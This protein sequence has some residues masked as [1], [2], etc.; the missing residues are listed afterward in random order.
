MQQTIKLTSK[1]KRL[2]KVKLKYDV[3]RISAQDKIDAKKKVAI[4]AFS[5]ASFA[6]WTANCEEMKEQNRSKDD[7]VQIVRNFLFT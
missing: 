4:V 5:A 6:M 2:F 1:A 7:F 3:S